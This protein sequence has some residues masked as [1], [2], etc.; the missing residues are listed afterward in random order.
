M[1]EILVFDPATGQIR[2]TNAA[3]IVNLSGSINING[4]LSVNNS[5]VLTQADPA[6][7]HTH[8]AADINAGTLA[9]ARI[10]PIPLTKLSGTLNGV[11]TNPAA[12][13]NTA[14]GLVLLDNTG[15]IPTALIPQIIQS[16]YRIYDGG[17]FPVHDWAQNRAG[18]V[19][20]DPLPRYTH[21]NIV[22]SAPG[23]ITV[24][25]GTAS[26]T[27]AYNPTLTPSKQVFSF[28]V[29]AGK[30]RFLFLDYHFK[31][32][33][34]GIRTIGGQGGAPTT[35]DLI[36]GFGAGYMSEIV[37][38]ADCGYQLTTIGAVPLAVINDKAF[39]QMVTKAY[40][41]NGVN[42]SGVV[43]PTN[44]TGV[45]VLGQGGYTKTI[46]YAHSTYGGGF[47]AG[48][49]QLAL[50]H[51]TYG[52]LQFTAGNGDVTVQLASWCCVGTGGF[53]PQQTG[54]YTCH[55]INFQ[56]LRNFFLLWGD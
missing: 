3:D 34:S 9:L 19:V 12:A 44:I 54:S 47:V 18:G 6:P 40:I 2:N 31:V 41:T 36:T 38:Y 26:S 46:A 15:K 5:R 53:Y 4:S 7:P 45:G 27:T 48:P 17:T 43:A 51:R 21:A 25:G 16:G 49:V 37:L 30:T 32:L 1:A 39:S 13:F 56:V 55:Y 23:W 10:P 50:T 42:K 33:A 24:V 20:G 8:N 14:N 29:P 35:N 22:W 52:V 11:A 28:I